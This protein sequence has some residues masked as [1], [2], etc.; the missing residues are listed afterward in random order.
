MK[1]ILL[2]VSMLILA[3]LACDLNVTVAPSAT[4]PTA[5]TIPILV[6]NTPTQVP[7]GTTS[8][9]S[10]LAPTRTPIVVTPVPTQIQLNGI[11]LA[12]QGAHL[13]A[14][15][16]PNCPAAPVGT[17]YL[18]VTL[19]AQNLPSDQFLDYKNLPQG[20]AIH[21]NTGAMT[22]LNRLAK[23]APELQQLTLY[24]AVPQAATAFGLQWPGATETPLTVAIVA[25]PAPVSWTTTFYGITLN[26]PQAIASEAS[27]GEI[28][29]LDRP[30]A[31]YWQKTPGHRYIS[32]SNNY[33][34]QGKTYQP[35]IYVYPATD[36]AVMV[37]AAFESMHRIN[38]YLYNPTAPIAKDQ[39]PTVP[40][41]NSAQIIAS[42]V[43]PLTFQSGRGMRMVSWSS[44]GLEPV[45]NQDLFYHFEGLTNDGQYYIV[46][47]LP[48]TAPILQADGAP[49][50]IIPAGGVPMP[51][52]KSANPDMKGYYANVQQ[53]LD[54]LQNEAFTPSISQL[55][56]LIQ[57][58]QVA[59]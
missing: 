9:I 15:D 11:T 44:Q 58:M 39:L 33:I 46:A 14:C 36:Y 37:P 49:G 4:V 29:R 51:D 34:L 40:F 23:Y 41:L 22:T 45:T 52:L 12:V 25:E 47:I 53:A 42:R 57:S 27:G 32:L 7:A 6:I 26:I 31:A 16:M 24:F 3:A 35:A 19:R 50:A 21:D 38:N 48:V 30:D 5:A 10:T 20:I 8:A 2:F 43:Q 55:D 54:G 1:K 56:L 59:P 28:A 13:G 17:R 18:A